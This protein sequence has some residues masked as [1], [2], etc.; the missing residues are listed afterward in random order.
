VFERV[1]N[2]LDLDGFSTSQKLELVDHFFLCIAKQNFGVLEPS[3]EE[4]FVD[5]GFDNNLPLEIGKVGVC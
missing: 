4:T 3:E 2:D 5:G 1:G